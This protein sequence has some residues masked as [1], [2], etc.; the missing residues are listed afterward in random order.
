[1]IPYDFSIFYQG[2]YA[3]RITFLRDA[4]AIPG[5]MEGIDA[6]VATYVHKVLKLSLKDQGT[7]AI[8]LTVPDS[9]NTYKTRI[10][11][12]VE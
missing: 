7:R 1:M 11:A 5:A 12:K 10:W 8:A 3:S 2:D 4:N 9:S 6:R